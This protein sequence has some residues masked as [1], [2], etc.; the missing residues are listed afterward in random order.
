MNKSEFL[1]ALR[2]GL[3][4][5]PQDDIEERNRF[6]VGGFRIACGLCRW[7]RADVY[8]FHCGRQR[9]AGFGHAVGRTRLRGTFNIYVLRL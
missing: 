3:H 7:Q 6:F 1:G 9:C 8:F 4:G 2:K 5:L